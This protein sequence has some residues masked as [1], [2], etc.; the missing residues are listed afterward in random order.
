MACSSWSNLASV[1]AEMPSSSRSTS[2]AA[3]D[4]ASATIGRPELRHA[5]TT[6]RMAVVLPV[7]AGADRAAP[8]DLSNRTLGPGGLPVV[9]CASALLASLESL[10]DGCWVE[11]LTSPVAGRLDDAR[12]SIED[13]G[14]RVQRGAVLDEDRLP[15]GPAQ[16][17]RLWEGARGVDPD[18]PGRCGSS[19]TTASISWSRSATGIPG[20]AVG[21][22]SKVMDVPRRPGRP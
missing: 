12:L 11:A 9:Q 15:V 4:G 2:A 1:S 14:G 13:R 20:L 8:R 18:R 17:F 7:P 19:A 22:R 16:S 5:P 10:L 21:F 3:A 6:T